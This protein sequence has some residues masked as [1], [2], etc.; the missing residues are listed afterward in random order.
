MM[1]KSPKIKHIFLLVLLVAGLGLAAAPRAARASGDETFDKEE[2]YDEAARFFGETTEGLAKVIEKIFADE[3]RPN[4]YIVGEEASGAI[5]VGLRYGKG[6]LHRKGAAAIPVFWQGP[7]IG[8]DLGGDA[9][10][11]FVLVYKLER[12]ADLFQ[13][14]PT[15][16][17]RLYFVA[18]VGANIQRSG[19]VTLAPIRT[20]VGL[21]AGANVGY[22]HYTR[23]HS[24]IPF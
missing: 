17:G 15:V 10:K 21:R 24:W 2:I 23:E 14:F 18:G 5:G 16:D 7:S 22:T 19:D 12:T 1:V 3:G 9:S 6:E 20:G 11:V 13:R 8:F 4:A